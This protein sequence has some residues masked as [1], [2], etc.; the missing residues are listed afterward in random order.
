MRVTVLAL[1]LVV[2]LSGCGV[3]GMIASG[4]SDGTKYVINRFEESQQAQAGAQEG[5]GPAGAGSE[6]VVPDPVQAP[7]LPDY[8]ATSAPAPLTAPVTP[9]TKGVPLN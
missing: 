8:G 3:V 9:V 2:P 6:A 1:T 5:H 7:P 4:V